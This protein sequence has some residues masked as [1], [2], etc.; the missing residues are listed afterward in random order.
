MVTEVGMSPPPQYA[1]NSSL[2]RTTALAMGDTADGPSGQI[3]VCF[4]GQAIAGLIIGY[5]TIAL[6]LIMAIVMIGILGIGF[7]GMMSSY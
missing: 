2:N 1:W 3:V 4:G 5:V 6:G 7:L